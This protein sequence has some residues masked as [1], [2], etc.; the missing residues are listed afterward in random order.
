MANAG[1]ANQLSEQMLGRL[2]TLLN[3]FWGMLP[4][5]L[6]DATKDF[7]V[8]STTYLPLNA[9]VTLT[10]SI[11]IQADSHF[12]IIQINRDVRSAA[13]DETIVADP[14]MLVRLFDSGSGRQLQDNPVPS[15]NWFGY[16]QLPGYLPYPKVLK[17]AS[18]LTVEVENLTAATNY[19]VRLAFLGFKIFENMPQGQW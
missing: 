6:W 1:R 4:R 16:A 9:G 3:P 18:T 7:F 2:T 5:R 13:D 11:Q 15:E 10:N 14:S 12:M 17:R 19:N 8:Y